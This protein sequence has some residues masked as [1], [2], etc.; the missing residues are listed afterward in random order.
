MVDLISEICSGGK[1]IDEEFGVT[2]IFEK[3]LKMFRIEPELLEKAADVAGGGIV[4]RRPGPPFVPG[5]VYEL[6]ETA[7]NEEQSAFGKLGVHDVVGSATS[8]KFRECGAA[9]LVTLFVGAG[10]VKGNPLIFC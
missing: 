6:Q 3:Q 5:L 2:A 10:V 1:A 8:R 9:H 7:V 4:R